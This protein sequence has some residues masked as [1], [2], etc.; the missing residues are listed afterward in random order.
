MGPIPIT[1]LFLKYFVQGLMNLDILFKNKAQHAYNFY[2][3]K[4]PALP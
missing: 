1:Y 3:L 2:C 4:G